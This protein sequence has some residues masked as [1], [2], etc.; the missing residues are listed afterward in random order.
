M[1]GVAT[2]GEFARAIGFFSASS[3][4]FV[5]ILYIEEF[6]CNLMDIGLNVAKYWLWRAEL[7]VYVS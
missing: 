2:E 4:V 7:S 1:E 5:E 6:N 3:Q